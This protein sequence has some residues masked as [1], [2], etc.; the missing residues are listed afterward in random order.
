MDT[1]DELPLDKRSALRQTIPAI[2]VT[3]V[4]E[5][6]SSYHGELLEVSRAGVRCSL[7]AELPVG[8]KVLI[9]PPEG[10]DLR[11]VRGTIT[12]RIGPS[13]GRP[14][15]LEYGIRFADE[16]EVRRHQ[17]WLTLRKAA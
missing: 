11:P 12:R 15:A 5:E 17:W 7:S 3:V 4:D 10:F 13:E 8:A 9:E 2:P 1:H 14:G 16:A 6:N